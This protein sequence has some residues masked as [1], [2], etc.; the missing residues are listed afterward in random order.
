LW[1]REVTKENLRPRE[2]IRRRNILTGALEIN[3]KV[4]HMELLLNKIV[5]SEIKR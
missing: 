1:Q 3:P 4:G 5:S 2:M